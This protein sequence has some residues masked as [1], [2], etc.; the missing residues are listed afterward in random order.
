MEFEQIVL[1][2]IIKKEKKEDGNGK[3]FS[4]IR[5]GKGLPT[6]SRRKE[7]KRRRGKK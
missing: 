7:K 1:V 6:K 5:K 2:K 3:P 4:L